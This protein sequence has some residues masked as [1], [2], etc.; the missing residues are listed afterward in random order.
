M[1]APIPVFKIRCVFFI[2]LLFIAFM[3]LGLTRRAFAYGMSCGCIVRDWS[4]NTNDVE[5]CETYATSAAMQAAFSAAVQAGQCSYSTFAEST[6]T[7]S[8]KACF[9]RKE[10][11]K[12]PIVYEYPADIFAFCV[13]PDENQDGVCDPCCKQEQDLARQYGG[14]D[15]YTIVDQDTCEGRCNDCV[16]EAEEQCPAPDII[17]WNDDGECSYNC[18]PD[19]DGDG[20]PDVSDPDADMDGDGLKNSEDDDD[21]GD[22]VPDVSD[23]D[24]DPDGDGKLN[25]E[26]DDDDG[27]G[28]PD[29]KDPDGDG[30]INSEDDDDDN[31]GVPDAEDP[32]NDKYHSS[33]LPYSVRS[34]LS[35]MM[36]ERFKAF[37]D[38][39]KMS[40]LFSI[41]DRIKGNIPSSGN[42]SFSVDMGEYGQHEV[43]FSGWSQGLAA[44]NAILYTV[45][46]GIAVR[47]I[48]L[49]R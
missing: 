32:D 31:D 17:V 33:E 26:D 47:I 25:W 13:C 23:L 9:R 28:I 14:S 15:T 48:I 16:A 35:Q 2:I 40:S 44:L 37:L 19:T 20:T 10:I 6:P 12:N 36:R 3:L 18:S 41:P 4:G 21:D 29:D 27:D 22:G 39:V 11:S 5:S 45:C 38:N 42:S 24:S 7:G 49:K 43:D 30:K 1:S 34:N 46:S 8:Y